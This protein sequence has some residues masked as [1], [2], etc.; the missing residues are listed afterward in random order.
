MMTGIAKSQ[1]CTSYIWIHV[2]KLPS[3]SCINNKHIFLMEH[4]LCT[5]HNAVS[6]LILNTLMQSRFYLHIP[7]DENEAQVCQIMCQ[8][9]TG[10]ECQRRVW[11]RSEFRWTRDFPTARWENVTQ[12]KNEFKVLKYTHKFVKCITEWHLIPTFVYMSVNGEVL[13]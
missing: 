10:C 1:G 2:A 4:L 6:H 11:T 5:R 9:K 3:K 13:K 7:W 8:N 12:D